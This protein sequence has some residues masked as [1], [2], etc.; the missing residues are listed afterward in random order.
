ML[1][2]II[3]STCCLW[4]VLFLPNLEQNS[5]QAPTRWWVCTFTSAAN[6]SSSAKDNLREGFF[7]GPEEMNAEV[8]KRVGWRRLLDNRK[9]MRQWDEESAL[10]VWKQKL[11][12]DGWEKQSRI[13]LLLLLL[14]ILPI[15]VLVL[16]LAS[17]SSWSSSS[18]SSPLSSSS[19]PPPSPSPSLLQ[20][21]HNYYCYCYLSVVCR[22]H[23]SIC[24]NFHHFL[25]VNSDI[26]WYCWYE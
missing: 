7:D 21:E 1:Y 3:T 20:T 17:S 14:S 19:A 26:F 11:S 16:L 6:A 10:H 8:W 2:R 15:P 5:S 25:V 18:S 4:F 9:M 23:L 24:C 13:L 22:V 12:K